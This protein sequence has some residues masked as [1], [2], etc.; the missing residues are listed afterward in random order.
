MKSGSHS[1]S[2]K[3]RSSGKNVSG[4]E[5]KGGGLRRSTVSGRRLRG[6]G[7][8]MQGTPARSGRIRKNKVCGF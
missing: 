5:K 8:G 2:L 3:S 4:N 7:M 1:N 6:L